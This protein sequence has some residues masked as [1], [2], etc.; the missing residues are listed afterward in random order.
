[1]HISP[2]V[3]HVTTPYTLSSLTSGFEKTLVDPW[4]YERQKKVIA[5]FVKKFRKESQIIG[6][7]K[8]KN[9]VTS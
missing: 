1:M 3:S 9:P 4:G 2:L 6:K 5:E 8:I 7:F